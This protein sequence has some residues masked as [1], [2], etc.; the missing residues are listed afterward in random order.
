MSFGGERYWWAGEDLREVDKQSRRN[1]GR[2][3]NGA[4]KKV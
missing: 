3:Y 4:E 2:F 1:K